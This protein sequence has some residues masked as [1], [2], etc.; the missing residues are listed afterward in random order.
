[1]AFMRFVNDKKHD[2]M[3]PALTIWKRGQMQ[4]NTSAIKSLKLD[5]FKYVVLF[6]D[7]DTK[8]VGFDLVNYQDEPGAIP[9]RFQKNGQVLFSAIPFLRANKI[10]S[11]KSVR[12]KI[13][14]DHSGTGLF[15][16]V[17]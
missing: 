10:K 6:F 16:L 13:Y 7:N 17:A 8:Q 9:L 11:D 12:Y 4:F 3:E 14:D 1:M 5:N 2:N 15:I